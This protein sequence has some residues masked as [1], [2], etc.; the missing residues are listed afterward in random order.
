[1]SFTFVYYEQVDQLFF[2]QIADSP[3]KCVTS[4]KF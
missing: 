1:M 4:C 2:D 3:I